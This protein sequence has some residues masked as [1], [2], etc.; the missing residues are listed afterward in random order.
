V[1]GM[2]DLD[3]IFPVVVAAATDD[4]DDEA[5][6]DVS[7]EAADDSSSST[8]GCSMSAPETAGLITKDDLFVMVDLKGSG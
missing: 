6:A 8:G 3:G 1:V 7:A 2:S 4:A 5:A